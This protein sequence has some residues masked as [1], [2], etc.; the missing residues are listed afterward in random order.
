MKARETDT[1]GAR[2]RVLAAA[3]RNWTTLTP[4]TTPTTVRVQIRQPPDWQYVTTL[5][6]TRHQHHRLLAW[7]RDDL[8]VHTGTSTPERAAAVINAVLAELTAAGHTRLTTADL[9]DA[10][11]RI[12]RSHTWI[13]THITHLIDTGRLH[14]TR[15]PGHFRIA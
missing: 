12:G 13:A 11:D 15:R 2:A 4:D 10:A 3:L 7:L 14:E 6:L 8:T 5:D 9:V 1:S